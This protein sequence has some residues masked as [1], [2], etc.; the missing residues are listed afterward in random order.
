MTHILMRAMLCAGLAGMSVAASAQDVAKGRAV[1]L[2]CGACHTI[3]AGEPKMGPDLGAVYGRK[4]GTLAGY[5]YS[6]A[7]KSAGV[8]WDAGTL[9]TFLAAPRSLVPGTRMAFPGLANA[10]DRANVIAYLKS[11]R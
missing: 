2:R 6:P 10:A 8:T 7:M 9:D 11:L 1:F 5:A 4:A 3:D